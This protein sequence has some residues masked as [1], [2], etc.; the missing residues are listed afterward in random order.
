MMRTSLAAP[1]LAAYV[2]RLLA[3]H[4]PDGHAPR[5]D[6]LGHVRGSL[7]RVEYCFRRIERKYY[8]D[9]GTTIFDHLNADHMAAFLWFLG[10]TI[11]RDAGDEELPVRLSYLNKMMHGLDLFYSVPMPDIFLLVHPVGTVLGRATYGDYLVVYQNCTVGADG[12]EY[13]AFGE[14]AILYSRSSVLGRCD[15][16][17]NVVFAA[18]SFVVNLT[19]PAD[20]VVVG[21]Y[22]GHRLL[23]NGTTV[24]SRCFSAPPVAARPAAGPA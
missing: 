19:V 8:R 16:G 13:P 3:A 21:Q 18:N 23:P 14:G 6:L 10:N 9:G 12:D 7:E 24:R 4:L 22:P 20:T 11:W 1:D 2:C 15:V 17:P 5:D